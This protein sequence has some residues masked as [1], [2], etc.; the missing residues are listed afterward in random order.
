M[1]Q[2]LGVQ[3]S[4][5][6]REQARSIAHQLDF[7][8]T[9]GIAYEPDSGYA[10]PYA[11][12]V[13]YLASARDLGVEVHQMGPVRSVRIK[14]GGVEAVHTDKHDFATRVVVNV[15]GTWANVI[16]KMVQIAYPL[17]ITREQEVLF[18]P[19]AAE[20][21]PN[22]TVT[23]MC[24][25]IYFHPFGAEMLLGRGFPKEYQEVDPDNYSEAADQEFIEEAG[26]RLMKR[27][28]SMSEAMP[29]RGYS[30]LY[31]VTLRIGI[32]S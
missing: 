8:D 30:G 20:D 21:R 12:T 22:I 23:D 3:T 27:I 16:G 19:R 29:I 17:Q 4:I 13:S 24:N 6:S 10:D 32:P 2:R 14:N 5:I 18:R 1:Q 15:T 7:S 28:P 31:D 26:E 11:S 25:A 9:A